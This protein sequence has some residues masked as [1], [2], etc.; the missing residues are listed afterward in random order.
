MPKKA[1]GRK[2][3][4]AGDDEEVARAKG[5]RVT[6]PMSRYSTRKLEDVSDRG[7]VFGGAKRTKELYRACHR[8]NMFEPVYKRSIN[9]MVPAI[10]TY[11]ATTSTR[12]RGAGISVSA[13][14]VV[15]G[16]VSKAA[17]KKGEKLVVGS[18]ASKVPVRTMT[19]A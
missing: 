13:N 15:K 2:R 4:Q 7:Q 8:P 17:R 3:K 19:A 14:G 10:N 12:M 18:A 9:Q 6:V 1:K 16:R 5:G 11:E